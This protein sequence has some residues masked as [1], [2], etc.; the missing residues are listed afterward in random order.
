MDINR[1]TLVGHLTHDPEQKEVATGKRVTRIGIATNHRTKP[2]D[3][4][5]TEIVEFHNIS[6]WGAL[7]E[8]ATT[9]LTKGKRVLVEG[10]L[11][12]YKAKTADP[13]TPPR[14]EIVGD[15]LILLDPKPKSDQS[16]PLT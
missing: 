8:R 6:L 10:R 1:V 3:G 12:Y 7:G 16:V 5:V 15:T 14:A 9:Y 11:H 2:K 4:E 13:K